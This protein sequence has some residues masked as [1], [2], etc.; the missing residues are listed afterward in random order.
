MKL[1]AD[2][3]TFDG[4]LQMVIVFSPAIHERLK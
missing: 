4:V 3:T 1:T 2:K